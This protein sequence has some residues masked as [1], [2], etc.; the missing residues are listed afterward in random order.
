DRPEGKDG[1]R[2]QGIGVLE[3][4]PCPSGEYG[5]WA[6]FEQSNG[7]TLLEGAV[8]RV[9]PRD[10]RDPIPMGD[11]AL[12]LFRHSVVHGNGDVLDD[13]EDVRTRPVAAGA[14]RSL[15]A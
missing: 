4:V 5:R 12:D 15:D 7:E 6:V 8:P 13:D 9:S 2:R 11:E 1:R 3:D 10:H 14:R